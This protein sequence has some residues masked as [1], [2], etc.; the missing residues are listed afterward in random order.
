L[1]DNI[2]GQ[3]GR[4]ID[5]TLLEMKLQDVGGDKAASPSDGAAT[6]SAPP[7]SEKQAPSANSAGA[8]GQP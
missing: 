8:E 5:R 6:E 7:A 1:A 4:T 3:A 2:D